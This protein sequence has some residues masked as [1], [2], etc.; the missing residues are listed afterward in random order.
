MYEHFKGTVHPK[1]RIFSG[2]FLTLMLFKTNMTL[3]HKRYR[4]EQIETF[5]I[6]YL[7]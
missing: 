2:P 4:N 3:E 7:L 5:T 6:Y 1:K